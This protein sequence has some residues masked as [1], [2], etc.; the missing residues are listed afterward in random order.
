M[1]QTLKK[2]LSS[3]TCANCRLCCFFDGYSAW[4]TPTFTSEEAE[5]VL[6]ITPQAKPV[7]IGKC[8]RFRLDSTS[9][10][11]RGLYPCPA[12]D[13]EDGC[14]L[15]DNK[16]FECA[17]WP[18]RIMNDNGVRVIGIARMCEAMYSK[19][20]DELSSFLEEDGLAEKIFGY[21]DKY[22]D[23]IKDFSSDYIMLKKINK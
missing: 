3:E 6:Q 19:P 17:I 8:K 7:N 22:P 18:Y 20:L 5:A 4:D 9:P 23:I 13:P 2:I 15:G 21:A 12:L 14:I 11:I 16:P 10:D 1:I